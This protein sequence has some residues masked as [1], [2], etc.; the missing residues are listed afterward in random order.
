MQ[1]P[2]MLYKAA[3]YLRLS[4]EDGDF[5]ISPGK[6]E[7]NS[8]SS[9]RDLITRYVGNMADI[10]LVAE[11]CDDGYTGTNFDRPEFQ[12]MMEA[13]RRGEIN[14]IIV[15]DLSRFGRDYIEA[16]KYI[17]KIFPQMGVRF[18][19]I[20]DQYDS[21]NA[22][23]GSDS[24]ILP[25][26][27]LINDS[28]SR[29]ISIKVRS[30]LES[31]RR[32][33]EFIAN[34]PV[35]GY[36]RSPEDKNQLVVDELAAGTV[37]DIFR[38]KIEGM[39]AQ[40][41]ADKLNARGTLPPME[42]KKNSGSRYASCFKTTGAAKWSA[43]AVIRILTNEV[44]TGTLV[45]GRRTTPNYKVKKVIVKDE[46]EW[47]RTE[48]AH[49]AIISVA[50][51][52]LVQMLMENEGRSAPGAEAVH[53]LSGMVFCG[54]CGTPAKRSTVKSKGRKYVYYNCVHSFHRTKKQNDDTLPTLEGDNC[55]SCCIKEQELEAA[56]LATLQAQI[57][58]IL[59][60]EKALAQVDALAW[61]KRELKR[62]DAEITV[63]QDIIDKNNEFK[64]GIYEDLR[65]GLIS[66]DEFHSLKEQ[67]SARIQAA[68]DAVA[69]LK[70]ERDVV[71]EGL[72]GQQG[73][74]AQFHLYQT[75]TSLDRA[76]IVNLVEK[77]TLYPD[78]QIDVKLRHQNQFAGIMEFLD[79]Q[80]ITLAG[81]T[82]EDTAKEAG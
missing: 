55:P 57:A 2:D 77:I 31:K 80:G 18:I 45:Q 72:D 71:K 62:L 3:D 69:N 56:V 1:K 59:D 53:P 10:E 79:S 60:M 49:E 42:H 19:A 63:Q 33:G 35:Y 34:F 12:K 25:F 17:E 68:G 47:S 13:I 20:N 43:V 29:D 4:K 75:V 38:W 9:Q 27:N 48:G 15:K 66:K 14:C 39:S 24:I 6:Q 5:S 67:F 21:L 54:S 7:S 30:N 64:V 32:R 58:L 40:K 16:G 11:Y 50:E 41:I 8:I 81:E 22:S 74:L 23:G 46:S 65:D 73:W 52:N 82:A 76:L 28:Y 37:R 44:Y 26:K 70:R 36:S 61:E 51:F 78:R